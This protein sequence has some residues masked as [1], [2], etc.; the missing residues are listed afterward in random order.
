VEREA[1]NSSIIMSEKQ[2]DGF[3][4]VGT[5]S[6][7]G[8][9]DLLANEWGCSSGEKRTGVQWKFLHTGKGKGKIGISLRISLTSTKKKRV[10]N[11]EMSM[12]GGRGGTLGW[13]GNTIKIQGP[14]K[15]SRGDIP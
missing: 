5:L 4:R 13:K 9:S 12:G 1:L 11:V 7:G 6:R 8:R 10:Q 14:A 15:F 2:G 3:I